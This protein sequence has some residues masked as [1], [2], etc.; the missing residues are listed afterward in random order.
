MLIEY[1]GR[2]S[3][4]LTW[5]SLTKKTSE[6]FREEN[7]VLQIWISI[8]WSQNVCL[9]RYWRCFSRKH[10]FPVSLFL[11]VWKYMS[12]E[13]T[14]LSDKGCVDLLVL[15]ENPHQDLPSFINFL[16]NTFCLPTPQGAK[17][18]IRISLLTHWPIRLMF[19]WLS[20]MNYTLS[21]NLLTL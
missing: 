13:C 19:S 9:S 2:T 11:A 18:G 1:L 17:W 3:A 5:H 4:V 8:W 7:E 6:R 16:W 14:L 12:T 15:S 20:A 21:K 10:N